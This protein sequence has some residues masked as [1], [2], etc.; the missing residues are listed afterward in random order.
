[1]KP[2]RT[3]RFVA[4]LIAVISMLFTQLAVASYRCPGMAQPARLA[5]AAGSDMQAM[6]GCAGMDLELPGLCQAMDQTGQQS[7][8]KPD[9]PQVAPFMAVGPALVLAA[10]ACMDPPATVAPDTGLLT[11]TTAPPLTIRHCCFRI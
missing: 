11:R 9:L 3:I 7:L 8:D 5:A 6:A 1:M 10:P 4:A 2:S